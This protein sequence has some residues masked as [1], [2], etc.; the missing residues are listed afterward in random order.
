LPQQFHLVVQLGNLAL[1]PQ[2]LVSHRRFQYSKL[3]LR[4]C[5]DCQ[6]STF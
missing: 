5:V 1:V 3:S 2:S 4:I 6:S